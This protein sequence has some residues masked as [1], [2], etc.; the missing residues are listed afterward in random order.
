MTNE[1]KFTEAIISFIY[2]RFVY[3]T[4]LYHSWEQRKHRIFIA[5]VKGKFVYLLYFNRTSDDYSSTE[6]VGQAEGIL[7]ASF[8][9]FF[10]KQ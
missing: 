7:N 8:I 2:V 4:S 9:F 10:L 3:K 1:I 6:W 5:E